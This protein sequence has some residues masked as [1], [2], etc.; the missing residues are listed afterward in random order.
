MVVESFS[1]Q[2]QGSDNRQLLIGL[3]AVVAAVLAGAGVVQMAR[4]R[5]YA[6]ALSLAGALGPPALATFLLA[7]AARRYAGGNR[8]GGRS[9]LTA[10]GVVLLVCAAAGALVLGSAEAGAV[11][12]ALLGLEVAVAVGVFYSWVYRALGTGR[13]I[14]LMLLRAA[15]ILALLLILF[16]PALSRTIGGPGSMP[17]LPILIDRS[18]S[19]ATVEQGGVSR[20]AQAVQVLSYQRQRL[21]KHF[22]PAWLHFARS[23]Q[24]ASS[25]DEIAELRPAGEGADGTDLAQAIRAATAGHVRA[26]LPG[27]LL[28]TD[29]VHNLAANVLDAVVEAGV[30]IYTVGAGS[31]KEGGQAGR[32]NVQI[33]SA[34]APLEVI[35]NNVATVAVRIQTTGMGYASLQAQ[36]Q[37]D[38]SDQVLVSQ[39]LERAEQTTLVQTV[40]LKWTPRD[41]PRLEADPAL[42]SRLRKLRVVVPPG[43]NEAA[44]EDNAADVH[45]LVTEPHI[46]VLYVEGTM[47]PEYKYLHR[48]LETDSNVQYMGLVRVSGNR[49]LAQGGIA[50]RKLESLPAGP[51]DFAMF[52]VII[53]GDLDRTFLTREQMAQVRQFVNNGGGLLMLGGHNSYGPGGYEGQDI[54]AAL[55]VLVGPRGS[56]QETTPF[57]PQLTAEGE[58]HPI[59]EGIAGYFFGPGGRKPQDGLPKLP[60]LMGCVT[61]LAAKPGAAV[62]AV[63]PSR[64]N[65]A[66]PLIALA[67]QRYGAG[68]SAAFTADTTWKW[69]LPLAGMGAE[70]PYQQFWGQLIRWLANAETKSRKASAAVVMRVDRQALQIGQTARIIALVDDEA[71]RAT[72]SAQVVCRVLP[73]DK[74]AQEEA[75]P[76]TP[77]DTAGLFEASFRPQHQGQYRLVVTATDASGKALGSDELP[78]SVAAHSAELDILARNEDLL[79]RI[80]QRSEGKYDDIS[81]LP[82]VIDQI[83][84]RQKHLAGTAPQTE[85]LRLYNFP[86][87]FLLFVGLLTA[88]WILRRNWQLQ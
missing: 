35:Q 20:Y 6:G 40:Q 58:A 51:E 8:R 65:E 66:G 31:A 78:L 54:E 11:W 26:D 24:A 30:P 81:R 37:E 41:T 63:H 86:A 38:G 64:R 3:L 18:A 4:R 28:V 77:T 39:P 74:A 71:G 48:L 42:P 87:L 47:R 21:G 33:L 13:M 17:P 15:A 27:V 83:I 59:F 1:L 76:L 34:E 50:G 25:L 75:L 85:T 60:N 69:F 46:R 62:L 73:A 72:R 70:S 12:L 79:R 9:A 49:F 82:E 43:P 29:G 55:P 57:V 7:S 14:A 88:E 84:D 80:A 52:D 45:V 32:P 5:W 56:A 36:L 19:M 53:M 10:A 68:R 23:T 44:T 61:V 22:R 16:K 67:V 2:F